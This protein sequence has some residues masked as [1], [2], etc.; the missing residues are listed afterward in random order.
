MT[1]FFCKTEWFER[2]AGRMTGFDLPG[3][4]G[5]SSPIYRSLADGRELPDF[6]LP[7]GALFAA[8]TVES[9]P[10]LCGSD[11]LSIV[12]IV[13]GHCHWW[14]DGRA[15]NCDRPDDWA[16]RCW[17]RHGTVGQLVTVNKQGGLTCS[18][19]AGSIQVKGWHGWL[20]NGELR[21]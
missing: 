20:Q 1:Q 3:R 5:I 6:E 10:N 13:P 2:I 21:I 16:H 4:D 8:G 15:S 9:Y 18:A 12:C 17:V 14:I 19:G 11:G 7:I